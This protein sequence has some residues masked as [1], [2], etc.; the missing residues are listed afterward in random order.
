M[1]SGGDERPY[2]ASE[3]LTLALF[4]LACMFFFIAGG[5]EHKGAFEVLAVACIGAAVVTGLAGLPRRKD[6]PK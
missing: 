1:K 2:S 5:V 3:K 6:S 4:G